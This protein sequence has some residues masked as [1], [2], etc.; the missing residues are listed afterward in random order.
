MVDGFAITG[1]LLGFASGGAG[2]CAYGLATLR[3]SA[4]LAIRITAIAEFRP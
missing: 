4:S 2:S 3:V 1:H